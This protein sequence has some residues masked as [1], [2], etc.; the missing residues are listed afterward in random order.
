[1]PSD[2]N[3]DYLQLKVTPNAARNAITGYVN[4]LL[5]V[6][7]VASPIKGKANRE[8]IDLLSCVL[9]VKKSAISIVKGV[10]GALK[11]DLD[12]SL[13][14]KKLNWPEQQKLA[15]DP[16]KFQ[17]VRKKRK[18]KSAACSMCGD[19]CAMRIVS[20]FL[21]SPGEADDFRC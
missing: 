19:F 17:E 6:K 21:G 3:S 18:S 14:R 4:G 9:G 16:Y 7:I 2:S 13:A 10:K 20:D 15:L 1:M 5:H 11:R 8:L 12:I